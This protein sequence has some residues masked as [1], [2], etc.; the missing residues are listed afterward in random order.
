[1]S[2]L[3]VRDIEHTLSLAF[4]FTVLW[5]GPYKQTEYNVL[6]EKL[7]TGTF[8]EFFWIFFWNDKSI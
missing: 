7:H 2:T 8:D 1:M 4:L 5:S 3:F 6:W